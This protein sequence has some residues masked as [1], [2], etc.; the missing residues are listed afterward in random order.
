MIWQALMPQSTCVRLRAR[1]VAVALHTSPPHCSQENCLY[2]ALRVL[3]R[4]LQHPTREWDK[5]PFLKILPC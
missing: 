3:P 5:P 4:H 1:S 2:I